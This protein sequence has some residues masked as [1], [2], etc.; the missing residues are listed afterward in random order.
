MSAV[1][2]Q[3]ITG[4]GDRQI[5]VSGRIWIHSPRGSG[6]GTWN[7]VHASSA[8]VLHGWP[9]APFEVRASYVARVFDGEWEGDNLKVTTT[10]LKE[11]WIR[12]NGL[13]RSENA[14]VVEYYIRH[15]DVLTV[16]MDVKDPNYLTEPL[17]RTSSWVAHRDG[18]QFIRIIVFRASKCLIRKGMSPT[19]YPGRILCWA[20][21][22]PDGVFRS[23][24][25]VGEPKRC[26]R[27]S[28]ETGDHASSASPSGEK[29]TMK[30]RMLR[31]P[32]HRNRSF[33]PICV[34]GVLSFQT[35]SRFQSVKLAAETICGP[36][37]GPAI[38]CRRRNLLSARQWEV[39]LL[40]V[41][42]N[43]YMISGA[44]SNITVQIGD[45]VVM[46]DTGC[47]RDERQGNN[48]DPY[49]H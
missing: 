5:C 45:A 20:S 4:L 40:H 6:L 44:G 39:H 24:P 41:Q 35:E 15:H 48:G 3:R 38:Y 8:I 37:I 17:I 47:G 7:D 14:T 28:A 43:V 46:V 13:P 16:V 26:M 23:R 49:P 34:G 12:R 36:W 18:F 19:I 42:D 22:H 10:H 27:Q 21:L 2:I 33:N 9:A 25:R 32:N 1:S 11:G 29:T 31:S 30:A